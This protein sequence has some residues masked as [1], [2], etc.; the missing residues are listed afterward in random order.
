MTVLPIE[1]EYSSEA[2]IFDIQCFSLH[3]GPG[4]RTTVFFKGCPLNCIWCHNPES[5]NRK[6][7]LMFH[8]NLCVG[9]MHCVEACTYGVHMVLDT[10]SGPVHQVDQM[11]CTGCGKCL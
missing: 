4:I 7:E 5:K 1:M 9:C 6:K 11:K 8:R 2:V 10:G 3:D